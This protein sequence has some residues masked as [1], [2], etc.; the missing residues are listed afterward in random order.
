MGPRCYIHCMI[1]QVT[2]E[3]GEPQNKYR[4]FWPRMNKDMEQYVKECGQCM[5]RKTLPQRSA[6]IMSSGPLYLVC[7]NFLSI[8]VTGSLELL[9]LPC[10][11]EAVE[12]ACV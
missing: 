9:T 2:L 4:F 8:E 10:H 1:N 11:G 3:L 12:L 7:I 6:Y 5:A